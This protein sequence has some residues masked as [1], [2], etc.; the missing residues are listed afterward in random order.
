LHFVLAE[1]K[2]SFKLQLPKPI[3]SDI[4]VK[5]SIFVAYTRPHPIKI[6]EIKVVN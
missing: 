2:F 4:T 5:T 6:N 3:D 1:V